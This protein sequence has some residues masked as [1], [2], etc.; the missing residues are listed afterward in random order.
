MSV[1]HPGLFLLIERFPDRRRTFSRLYA[2]HEDFQS[3]CENYQQCSTALRYWTDS[4]DENAPARHQEYGEI[5]Q[6]LEMEIMD[7]CSD[8][9]SVG[10]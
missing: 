5:L 1:I 6:E 9:L 2:D 3:L 8:D 4:K 10:F 7:F